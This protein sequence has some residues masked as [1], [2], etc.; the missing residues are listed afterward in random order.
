MIDKVES[1]ASW[2][3]SN[4]ISNT[5]R[6]LKGNALREYKQTITLSQIQ[7][8]VLVGTLLGDASIPL[9]R[10]KPR[11]NVKFAQKS[12]SADYIQHLYSVFYNPVGRLCWHTS[13][14][15]EYSWRWRAGSK[16]DLVSNLW[17]PLVYLI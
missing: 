1:Q 15:T 13:A 14:S 11:L 16:T 17:S 7:R 10:G 9:Y 3:L 2:Q 8:E 5:R 12:A 4:K 6:A